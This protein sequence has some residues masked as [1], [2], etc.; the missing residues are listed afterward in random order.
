MAKHLAPKKKHELNFIKKIPKRVNGQQAVRKREAKAEI[1]DAKTVKSARQL[2]ALG[3]HPWIFYAASLILLAVIQFLPLDSWKIPA[4]YAIPAL[5]SFPE[6]VLAAYE[7]AVKERYRF[8]S[9]G[10]AMF[11]E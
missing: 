9:F 5:L 3:R 10:D 4:A 2:P 8:F 7:E 6:H 1:P 11:I